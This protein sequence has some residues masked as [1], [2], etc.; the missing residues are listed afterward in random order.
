MNKENLLIKYPKTVAKIESFRL[1]EDGWDGYDAKPLTCSAFVRAYEVL[2]F[3][4][5]KLGG[6]NDNNLS[7]CVAPSPMN[8]IEF[9]FIYDGF[10][11]L[12]S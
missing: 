8:E 4:D 7:L 5:Q 2:F 3:I 12:I 1:L 10:E 6:L 9:E 11:I